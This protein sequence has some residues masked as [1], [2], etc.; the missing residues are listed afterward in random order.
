MEDFL[1][2]ILFVKGASPPTRFFDTPQKIRKRFL[3]SL[4]H[5]RVVETVQ[6]YFVLITKWINPARAAL[7]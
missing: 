6:P 4:K 1:F 2:N 3:F 5:L 7:T